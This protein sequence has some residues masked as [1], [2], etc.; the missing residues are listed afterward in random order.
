M[1]TEHAL[2]G[3]FVAIVA[4]FDRNGDLDTDSFNKLAQRLVDQ[5]VHRLVVNGTTGESPTIESDELDR[6]IHSVQQLSS[7]SRRIP[8]IVGTGTNN[9]TTTIHKTKQAK[10]MGADAALVV[11]PYYNRPSQKGIIQHFR[12]LEDADLP[13]ILYDI[14]HRTGVSLEMDTIKAIMEMDH[15]IGIKE[16]TDNMKQRVSELTRSIRKP[17]LCGEDDSL[18]TSLYCGATGGILA[19]ANVH[20][21]QFVQV[22]ELFRSGK[23]EESKQ[24]FHKLLPLVRLLFAEPNPAPLKWLLARHG[25]IRTDQLRL[26]MTTISTEL[27]QQLNTFVSGE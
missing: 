12:Y 20:S 18:W 27:Q 24:L 16:S 8:I 3:I 15:V 9:T 5:G 21:D 2:H 10:D 13:I 17:V 4:P 19:S 1:L 7:Q 6:M 25:H 11:T 26:P 22:Y 23:I 14:P